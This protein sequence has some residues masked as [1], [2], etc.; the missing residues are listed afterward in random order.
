M[1]LL[2]EMFKEI[3]ITVDEGMKLLSDEQREQ[4]SSTSVSL[5]SDG[6]WFATFTEKNTNAKAYLNFE[7]DAE[8]N[9]L[10][11]TNS[12]EYSEGFSDKGKA[13]IETLHK[14]TSEAMTLHT[15][16][17]VLN[18]IKNEVS[19]FD[20]ILPNGEDAIYSSLFLE[21]GG[22][23]RLEAVISVIREETAKASPTQE[24]A[25]TM[26]NF[27]I[28]ME[29]IGLAHT[30]AEQSISD[31]TISEKENT[32]MAF[33]NNWGNTVKSDTPKEEARAYIDKD[34]RSL[35]ENNPEIQ[36]LAEGTLAKAKE[37]MEAVH[38]GG[39]DIDR[40][41]K[42]KQHY[43]AKA[44]VHVEQAEKWDK[45]A[46]GYVPMTK[47]DGSPIYK[48]T[49]ELKN[50][51]GHTLTFYA[52]KRGDEVEF[53][54]VNAS[55][56]QKNFQTDRRE[57][58][59]FKQDE[60][61]K[62]SL[63]P[64]IKAVA[65]LAEEQ[66][67]IHPK[68]ASRDSMLFEFSKFANEQFAEMG[69][70]VINEKGEEV[71]NVYASFDRAENGSESVTLAAHYLPDGTESQASVRLFADREGNPSAQL[72]DWSRTD[73]QN[74]QGEKEV[75]PREPDSKQPPH[76][77]FIN[78]PKD[79]IAAMEHGLHEE[80]ANATAAFKGFGAE[81]EQTKNKP[82]QAEMEH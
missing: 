37:L 7:F 1:S 79:L 77:E 65:K 52:S 5:Q 19:D 33:E 55:K 11:L 40:T 42:D 25:A 67:M 20:E 48:A 82:K 6:K 43:T 17:S 76:K 12:I 56:W 47:E 34:T 62:A 66:G 29:T 81:Q 30:S 9:L 35:M 61:A 64:D 28:T 80:I 10:S 78:S 2:D 60:I 75:V 63:A 27:C 15:I 51:K 54:A 21:Q 39:L 44:V 58:K 13:M 57:F 36:A 71:K 41:T 31:K 4:I 23:E 14:N 8:Q 32:T 53:S 68:E 72:V 70:N 3:T 73:I 26:E 18:N 24:Q 38:E 45:E 59:L 74:E 49:A 46:K 22:K 69:E 50:D 16:A